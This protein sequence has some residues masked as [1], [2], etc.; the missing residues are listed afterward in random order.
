MGISKVTRNC[1]IT[2]PKDVRTAVGVKEGDQIMFIIDGDKVKL[3]K[4]K[5]DIIQRTAGIWGDIGETGLEYQKRIR[6]EGEKRLKRL[7]GSR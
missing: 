4:V 6:K 5:D 3:T 2:I 1:Q 7:Y